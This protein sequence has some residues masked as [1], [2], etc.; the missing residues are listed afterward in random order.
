[1]LALSEIHQ[2]SQCYRFY[3]LLFLNAIRCLKI[4]KWTLFE[5]FKTFLIFWTF[6]WVKSSVFLAYTVICLIIR[7][8][9]ICDM[10]THQSFKVKHKIDNQMPGKH[11]LN[12]LWT[13]CDPC[14]NDFE[15]KHFLLMLDKVHN[16]QWWLSF[17]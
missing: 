14:E 11:V 1:M 13:L 10:L 16:C 4:K 15:M 6:C 3:I 8:T 7:I 17:L 2:F 12:A 5:T 9:W